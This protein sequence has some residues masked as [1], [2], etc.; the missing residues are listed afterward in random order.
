MGISVWDKI[1]DA[2]LHLLKITEV[3][4]E[5]SPYIDLYIVYI[6]ELFYYFIIYLLYLFY[7]RGLLYYLSYLPLAD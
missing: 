3:S 1:K 4:Y 7:Y 2:K 6:I 5:K